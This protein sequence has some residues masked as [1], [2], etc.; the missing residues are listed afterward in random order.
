VTAGTMPGTSSGRPSP[1]WKPW[2]AL[3]PKD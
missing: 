3:T 2:P 1:P